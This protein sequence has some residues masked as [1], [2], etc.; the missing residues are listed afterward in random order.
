MHTWNY[1]EQNVGLK[2]KMWHYSQQLVL[3][4][5]PG[6]HLSSHKFFKNGIFCQVQHSW[7]QL[8]VSN[9][10]NCQLQ[11]GGEGRNYPLTQDAMNMVLDISERWLKGFQLNAPLL[12]VTKGCNST[13]F[14]YLLSLFDTKIQLL[15]HKICHLK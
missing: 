4:L 3:I 1:K 5:I 11:A 15:V 13:T 6:F 9:I 10:T 14:T 12:H 8:Y 7:L 2:M